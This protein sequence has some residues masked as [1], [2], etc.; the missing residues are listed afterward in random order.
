M[1]LRIGPNKVL[2]LIVLV[3]V[4]HYIPVKGQPPY[5]A[6]MANKEILTSAPAKSSNINGPEIYGTRPAM[7]FI[8]RIPGRDRTFYFE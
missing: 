2:I 6:R 8:C 1:T 7:K 3:L 5:D 4:S